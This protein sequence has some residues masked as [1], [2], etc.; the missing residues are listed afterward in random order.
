MP[1]NFPA[2]WEAVRRGQYELAFDAPHFTDYRRLK[3]GF[4]VLAK[5]PDSASYSLVVRS[6]EG[7]V[8]PGQLVGK[9]VAS[10]GLLSIG[11][12]RLNVLFPNALRQPILVDAGTAEE[13]LGSLRRRRVEA[14]FLPTTAV[15]RHIAA[16]GIA[17]LLT[18]EP[19]PPLGISASPRLP[20]ALRKKIRDGLLQAHRLEAGQSMLRAIALERF[21][22]AGAEDFANQSYVLRGYWGY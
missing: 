12:L 21:H 20:A 15:R 17:V 22:P 7:I 5:T 16:G 10:L 14:A 3:L 18:T 6:A 13:A 19:V 2:Y 4:I 8:D 9:R 1:P 11:T